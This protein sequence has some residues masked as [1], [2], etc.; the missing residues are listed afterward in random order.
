MG[1]PPPRQPSR[2][3]SRSSSAARAR[4]PSPS[5]RGPVVPSAKRSGPPGAMNSS[6]R[7]G[8]AS[9]GSTARS[10]SST[11]RS[12]STARSAP[13]A[14]TQRSHRTTSSSPGTSTRAAAAPSPARVPP[15]AS[16]PVSSRTAPA[17]PLHSPH[18]SAR[19]PQS[20][21]ELLDD[22]EMDRMLAKYLERYGQMPTGIMR[23]MA[24]HSHV[25]P[26]LPADPAAEVPATDAAEP[27][28]RHR[29]GAEGGLSE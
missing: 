2:S 3:S 19:R 6:E 14:R 8:D 15:L 28:S 26:P 13:S 22:M 12:T 16:P 11:A 4:G 29:D 5:R 18:E 24:Q 1:P 25:A 10:V 23:T 27:G 21:R 17:S 20:Q 9:P 7:P